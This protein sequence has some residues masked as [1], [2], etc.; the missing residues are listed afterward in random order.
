MKT[1]AT[2]SISFVLFYMVFQ[3]GRYYEDQ[4]ND[5]TNYGNRDDVEIIFDENNP[6]VIR[7]FSL[8][9]QKMIYI[10][11]FKVEETLDYN[12]D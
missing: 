1:V 9:Q 12:D 5:H 4:N 6:D 10:K 8:K 7:V 11:G 2:I 3:L